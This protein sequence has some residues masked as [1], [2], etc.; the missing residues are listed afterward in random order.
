MDCQLVPIGT[1]RDIFGVD[2]QRVLM[3]TNG[4][5]G[6]SC[7]AYSVTGNMC[8]YSD[9]IDDCFNVFHCNPQLY[10]QQT[11][12]GKMMPNLSHYCSSLKHAVAKISTQSVPSMLWL[13]DAHLIGYAMLYDIAVFVY[14][15]ASS[16]WVVYNETGSRGYI[17]LY[18]TGS[19][20]DVLR[21]AGGGTPPAPPSA[22]RY[23]CLSWHQ[24][25]LNKQYTFPGVWPWPAQQSANVP[26][27]DSPSHAHARLYSYADVARSA[28]PE[29][30]PYCR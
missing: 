26:S 27:G 2:Y 12:F 3:P 14:N 13:E 1:V 19:H 16:R 21:S 20:F 28:S 23:N 9:M 25:Q 22:E 10:I 29:P 15:S 17:C 11:E 24:V 6:F 18:F 7:F 4:L 30:P 5:C 8:G